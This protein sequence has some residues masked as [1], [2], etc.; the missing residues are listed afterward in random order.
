MAVISLVL[1]MQ[2]SMRQGF[3]RYVN[4][5]EKTGVSRL[6]TSLQE[7]YR[8]E[9]GWEFVLH[10]PALWHRLVIASMHVGG[11]PP[12]PG[13]P[14]DPSP[15]LETEGPPSRPFPPPLP[16]H[17]VHRFFLLDA[18]RKVL[19]GRIE[20]PVGS[21][22]TPLLH[23]GKIVGYA[24]MVP[25]EEMSEPHQ[26]R[27]IKEQSL[28]F[29]MVAGVVLLLATGLSLL[30]SKRLVRPLRGL[31][32]ATRQLAAGKFAT[33]VDVVSADELGQLADNFNT[34]AM[35]LEKNEQARQQWVADISHELRT[36][37]AIL[38]GEIE[39]LQDGIRQ[40]DSDS[41]R[42][43]HGEVLR[44][45]R[46]VDDLYQLTMSDLGA[47]TY[48]KEKLDIIGLLKETVASHDT[49][50]SD[51]GITLTSTLP[52]ENTVEI[53]G[54]AERLRQLF[55]N[56]LANSLKYTTAGGELR[57][58]TTCHERT[59]TI[60]F[61]DSAPGVAGADM[62][63]LFER[64]YRIEASRNRATGG[65]GLGLAICRNIVEAHQGKISA[66]SSPLGGLWVQVEL[67]RTKF[68]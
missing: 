32:E 1:I 49:K 21:E 39:A 67:P 45:T 4:T 66:Q 16:P 31:A 57:I 3:L 59:V 54:D 44:I 10:N 36:P 60:D 8:P 20:V 2:L 41:L 25:R 12:P 7:G 42:S 40:P 22:A 47:L 19:I 46:L 43:L 50:F 33:R 27:F 11:P 15:N 61:Q 56:L 53:L 24:G 26:A 30:L 64:L 38:R 52:R 18:D 48:Q 68:Q 23:Q 65:A 55:A 37:V 63:R 35:T 58:G 28:A 51:K 13:V 17:F 5:M 29:A 6:A 9:S 62:D 14:A 34:L